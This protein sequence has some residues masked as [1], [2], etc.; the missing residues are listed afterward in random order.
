MIKDHFVVNI[1]TPF[2]HNRAEVDIVIYPGRFL[3][4]GETDPKNAFNPVEITVI[5]CKF[6]IEF[7]IVLLFHDLGKFISIYRDV[8]PV[9]R[10]KR[11]THKT[12]G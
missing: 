8:F 1:G 11:N 7:G 12:Q 5:L 6:I 4:H 2:L 10:S 9:V 3:C